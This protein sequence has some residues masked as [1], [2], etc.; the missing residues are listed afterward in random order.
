M[1]ELN[2]YQFKAFRV[3]PIPEYSKLATKFYF[4]TISDAYNEECPQSYT[5]TVESFLFPH[6]GN[7][8]FFLEYCF[9]NFSF[10]VEG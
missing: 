1:S 7:F 9:L 2:S 6:Q 5:L 3:L 4:L 8:F 10:L